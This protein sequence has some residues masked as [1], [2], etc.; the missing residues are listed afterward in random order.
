MTHLAS[1]I[2]VPHVTLD[3]KKKESMSPVNLC[4]ATTEGG[5]FHLVLPEEHKLEHSVF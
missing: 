5:T 1:N 3:I 2:H 4:A